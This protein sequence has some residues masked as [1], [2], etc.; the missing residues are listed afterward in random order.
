MIRTNYS[1]KILLNTYFC[2]CLFISLLLLESG[3]RNTIPLKADFIYGTVPKRCS[4]Y[5]FSLL[6]ITFDNVNGW[7][8]LSNFHETLMGDDVTAHSICFCDACDNNIKH[9]KTDTPTPVRYE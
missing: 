3:I 6:A 9:I 4:M 2:V 7:F 1:R 5:V 8:L